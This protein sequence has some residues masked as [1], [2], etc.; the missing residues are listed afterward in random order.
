MTA[1]SVVP[2]LLL[3][4]WLELISVSGDLGYTRALA[5]FTNSLRSG[6]RT[7]CLHHGFLLS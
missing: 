7:S 1:P 6:E 5:A 4:H 3:H 2:I